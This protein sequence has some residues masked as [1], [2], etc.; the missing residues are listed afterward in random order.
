MRRGPLLLAPS[1]K[2]HTQPGRTRDREDLSPARAAERQPVPVTWTEASSEERARPPAF[3]PHAATR[4][5]RGEAAHG[6]LRIY[7]D[8]RAEN[9]M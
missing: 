1:R 4:A 6:S 8:A 5:S 2:P 7:G 3:P 9:G